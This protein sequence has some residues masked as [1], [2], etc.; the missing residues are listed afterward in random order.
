MLIGTAAGAHGVTGEMKV[1]PLTFDAKRFGLLDEVFLSRGDVREGFKIEKVRYQTKFVI[2]KLRAVD[3]MTRA[4]RYKGC[5][6]TI[7]RALA[8]PLGEDEYYIGDVIG[9]AVVDM[10]GV[11]IGELT[12]VIETGANDV[13][14]VTAATGREVLIPAVKKYIL[15]VDIKNKRMIAAPPGGPE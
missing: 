10:N 13:Y 2:I 14:A 15:S 6:V 8:L 11:A 12:G 7:P 4:A 9:C 3:D 1:F 5:D